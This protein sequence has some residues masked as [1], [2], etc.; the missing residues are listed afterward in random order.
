MFKATEMQMY[1]TICVYAD[2]RCQLYKEFANFELQE[3]KI[4]VLVAGRKLSLPIYGELAGQAQLVF[5]C[6]GTTC[7]HG[8]A[9]IL[10]A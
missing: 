3:A 2:I 4:S 7:V 5:L 6:S 10:F 1:H 9:S 8:R